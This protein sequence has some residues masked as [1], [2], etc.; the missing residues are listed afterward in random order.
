MLS[1]LSL[2]LPCAGVQ[3]MEQEITILINVKKDSSS[4]LI[5]IEMDCW[6][7]VASLVFPYLIDVLSQLL[8][9]AGCQMTYNLSCY[10][11]PDVK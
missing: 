10:R 4:L 9:V 7:I 2:S 1:V 5:F 8:H 6:L 11:L 3:I